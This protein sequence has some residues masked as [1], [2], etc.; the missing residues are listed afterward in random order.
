MLNPTPPTSGSV[1]DTYQ[2]PHGGFPPEILLTTLAT[3]LCPVEHKATRPP[4]SIN[5]RPL[6]LVTEV[7]RL[8]PWKSCIP[9]EHDWMCVRQGQ[10]CGRLSDTVWDPSEIAGSFLN[11]LL[12]TVKGTDAREQSGRR[13][14][15]PFLMP[16]PLTVGS[17]LLQANQASCVSPL[18]PVVTEWPWQAAPTVLSS[19]GRSGQISVMRPRPLENDLAFP[20]L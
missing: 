4:C 13:S 14:W 3:V 6:L 2:G 16:F 7:E 18:S 12:I 10:P 17:V 19:A 11:C 1:V 9:W 5:H 15:L 20:A 8:G